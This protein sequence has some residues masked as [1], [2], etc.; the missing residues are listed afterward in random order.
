M[1]NTQLIKQLFNHFMHFYI[2]LGGGERIVV[3][4]DG[5][6]E[7]YNPSDN[8]ADDPDSSISRSNWQ[9]MA[10]DD[11]V[12]K[13]IWSCISSDALSF[14]LEYLVNNVDKETVDMLLVCS[15]FDALDYMIK[16]IDMFFEEMEC[17]T[18][19]DYFLKNG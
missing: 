15:P 16:N 8:L 9:R 10:E 12:D 1:N 3:Y 13:I 18:D 19:K 7:W 4:K 2:R 6:Y 14:F 17:E 11:N 5:T